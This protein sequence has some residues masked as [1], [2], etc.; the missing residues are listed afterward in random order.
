[1][2][3]DR[4]KSLQ[5]AQKLIDKR[6]YDRAI[7]EYQKIVQQDPNDARTLLRIG[8]LQARLGSHAE[9]I[10]SYDRVALHYAGRG[11]SLKAIAVLKQIR[12]LIDRHAPHLVDRYSHVGPKLAQI[13]AELGHITDALATYDGVA[14]RLQET[15]RD[16]D[17]VEIIRRMVALDRSNPLPYLRLAEALCR[18]GRL[19]EAIEHF[20]SAAQL[21]NQGGRPEDALRVIERILHFRQDVRV[22]RVAAELYLARGTREA[23]M[24][25]L[26][27]LQACFQAD[28]QD[29]KTLALL[30]RAFQVIDQPQK[31]VEVYKEMVRIAQ[32]SGNV[33][34]AGEYLEHLKKAAPQDSLVVELTGHLLPGAPRRPPPRGASSSD[35][36]ESLPAE[37]IELLDEEEGLE[38]AGVDESYEEV[39]APERSQPVPAR[40]VAAAPR[41]SEMVRQALVDADSYRGLNLY[42]KALA[43]LHGAVE[44]EPRSIELRAALQQ[45]MLEAGDEPGAIAEMLQVA[46]LYTDDGNFDA[47]RAELDQVLGL[48]PG[49]PDARRMLAELDMIQSIPPGEGEAAVSRPTGEHEAFELTSA[50]VSH[51]PPSWMTPS[52]KP[53][54]MPPGRPSPPALPRPAPTPALSSAPPLPA[55]ELDPEELEEL[56]YRMEDSEAPSAHAPPPLEADDED[57][58]EALPSAHRL[59]DSDMMVTQVPPAPAH[60]AVVSSI[61][62]ADAP[63]PEFT[64]DELGAS[65]PAPPVQP[66]AQRAAPPPPLPPPARTRPPQASSQSSVPRMPAPPPPR[67]TLGDAPAPPSSVP[68]EA[69]SE[70][71]RNESIRAA[72]DEVEFFASR[73]LYHDAMAILRERLDHFPGDSQL[74]D[75]VADLEPKI[76]ADSGP[77]DVGSLKP[78]NSSGDSLLSAPPSAPQ[79]GISPAEGSALRARF[80]TDGHFGGGPILDADADTDAIVA[81]LGQEG[82][83]SEVDVDEV[84][85][86]FKQGVKAQISDNDSATHFDLGVAYKEMGL[87]ADAAREFE[88]ASKDPKR[89]C[90]SLAMMGMMYRQSGD[91][92]RAA[93]AY[94]RGLNAGHKTVSQEMSLYYELGCIYEEK[95]DPDEAIYYLQRITRR[96][97]GYRDV[98]ERIERLG[99]KAMRYSAPARAINDDDFDR[100]FDELYKVD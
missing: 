12:E 73:G 57:E 36:P 81:S 37:E 16:R 77:R 68:A 20:W 32:R 54:A 27:R 100:S 34:L 44:V 53:P 97:P 75:A 78:P 6:K 80:A 60:A 29:L 94:V 86:K 4:E 9:A 42:D 10:A 7:A 14:R 15:G 2:P 70:F 40:P 61:P 59:S 72:L 90:N 95:D 87:L 23:G 49:N 84:F 93:E 19:D 47:A 13:Y 26:S 43:T 18:I 45:V 1:M 22:C 41:S 66:G 89:E 58:D 38:E 24:L 28:E 39:A 48:S 65:P 71:E 64:L 56:E 74:L 8:D 79:D 98:M 5:L 46:S 17:A 31:S 63:L 55:Y 99:P 69:S 30:A 62:V 96:D 82:P 3:F 92:D 88:V 91:L 76:S 11:F 67:V 85:A 35:A 51:A 21:L 83:E 52:A 25:A 50:R 33:E